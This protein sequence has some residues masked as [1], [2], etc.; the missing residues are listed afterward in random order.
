VSSVTW[1]ANEISS[2][3]L[4]PHLVRDVSL[5]DGEVQLVKISVPPRIVGRTVADI[6]MTGEAMPFAIVRA[7]KSFIPASHETL[8]DAD[9]VEVAVLTSAMD[10]FQNLMNP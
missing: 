2:L 8:H 4:Y 9:I 6:T 1:A 3:V 5:G 10:R 7:G